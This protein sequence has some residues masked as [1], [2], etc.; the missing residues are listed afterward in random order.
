MIDLVH[1]IGGSYREL[2][3]ANSYPGEVRSIAKYENKMTLELPFYKGIASFIYMLL[4]AEVTYAVVGNEEEG[5]A[6]ELISRLTYGKAVEV[7]QADFIFI[8]SSASQMA[9]Q[10]AFEQ[11]KVGTLIDPHLSATLICE[12][13]C[14]NKGRAYDL[15]GPGIYEINTIYL[16]FF[17][18]WSKIRQVKNKE[19]PLGID[20]IFIDED[21]NLLALPRTTQ[22]KERL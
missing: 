2:V 17:E 13:D 1:D 4:D 15:N 12:V 10:S 20:M 16:D 5:A 19:F 14:V 11:A 3:N 9:K 6:S 21:S 7:H 8:L 22:L 18:G